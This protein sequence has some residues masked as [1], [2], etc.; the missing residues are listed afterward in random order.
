MKIFYWNNILD[1]LNTGI[2]NSF[3]E[4]GT[5]ISIGSFDG[6]HK[7]HRVLLNK[8]VL[9]CK[10]NN[11]QSGVV[12]FTRPLPSIKHANDYCG[13]ISS[14]KQRLKIFESLG[15]D[16]VIIVDF[17]EEFS[18]QLGADFL[19]ILINACNMEL[20]AEGVDFRCG[21]KG[22]TDV[23]AINYFAEKNKIKTI[24]VEPVY[25]R[26]GTDEEERISSSFIRDMITK[27]F[28][29]TVADLLDRPYEIDLSDCKNE[30]HGTKIEIL[31][32]EINQVIPSVGVYRV[33]DNDNKDVRMEVKQDKIVLKNVDGDKNHI[34]K[35]ILFK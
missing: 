25:Y 22:A 18:S 23:Q 30:Q 6:I 7:G 2:Q 11:L 10:S 17:D 13:D 26:E 31:G 29:T 32:N 34:V 21:Y 19:N 24:F 9:N 4:T 16:F 33:V 5:G 27:G 3:F 15:V 35:S 12:T 8:L 1:F 20:I 14:L 28:F